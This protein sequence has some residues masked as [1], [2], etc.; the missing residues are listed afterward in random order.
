MSNVTFAGDDR[1]TIFQDFN[2]K[3]GAD[4]ELPWA[5]VDT[6]SAGTPAADFSGDYPGE[7]SMTMTSNS[8]EELVGLDWDDYVGLDPEKNLVFEA[9]VKLTPAGGAYAST[10]RVLIGLAS[11]HNDDVDAITN[12]VWFRVGDA[13]S[14]A[15]KIESDDG[16]TN[17]DDQAGVEGN[18]EA[19]SVT[20]GSYSTYRIE[21]GDLSNIRFILDG[22]LIGTTSASAL[23]SGLQPYIVMEKDSG[24]DQHVMVVDYV[25]ITGDRD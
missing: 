18:G 19:A 5:K 4:L 8:Q 23:S 6:S 14:M 2:R 22:E 24:T 7:W 12:S 3:A 11:A 21:M 1:F 9:R 15:V 20:S 25:R 13:A 10:E 17:T 16:T